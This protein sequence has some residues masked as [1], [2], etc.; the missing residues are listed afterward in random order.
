[1]EDK[2][3]IA[4]A[5]APIILQQNLSEGKTIGENADSIAYQINTMTTKI[6]A[7]LHN[8]NY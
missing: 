1:M 6:V 2:I 4:V 3:K 8:I 7:R 5:I